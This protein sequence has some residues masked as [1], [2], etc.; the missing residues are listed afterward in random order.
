MFTSYT[1][2]YIIYHLYIIPVLYVICFGN[3]V[4]PSREVAKENFTQE[5]FKI[6]ILV[7]VKQWINLEVI[8]HFILSLWNL[9][10]TC[11]P[12]FFSK[13]KMKYQ[14]KKKFIFQYV[15]Y[16]IEPLFYT[17]MS[18]IK[19]GWFF[20]GLKCLLPNKLISRFDRG[21]EI[22]VNISYIKLME[23]SL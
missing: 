1:S 20:L 10:K 18:N 19:V 12:G 9:Y 8:F 3:C 14:Q 4:G 6:I 2:L 16:W 22:N 15:V 17:K 13:N 21:F 7:C 11:F 23:S 5:H